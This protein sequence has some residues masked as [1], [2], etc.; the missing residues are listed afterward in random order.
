M[1]QTE[2]MLR[3]QLRQLIGD[4]VPVEQVEQQISLINANLDKATELF[5]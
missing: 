3:E 1:E 5:Q 2:V 4:K